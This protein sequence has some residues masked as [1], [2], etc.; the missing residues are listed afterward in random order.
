MQGL[1]VIT[2]M[3]KT[4]SIF[5]LI[6]LLSHG[7]YSVN[8]LQIELGKSE[9]TIREY[10]STLERVGFKIEKNLTCKYYLKDINF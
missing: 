1:N 7:A 4:E 2:N 8:A 3:T 6:K 10:F 5:R 9:K